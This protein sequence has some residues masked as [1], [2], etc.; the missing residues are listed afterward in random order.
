[1]PKPNF[2]NIAK[3]HEIIRVDHAGEFG[4]QKI[5][6][7]QLAFT[8]DKKFKILIN[9]MLKQEEVHLK[10]FQDQII[11][12]RV[13]PTALMPL[14]NMGGYLLGAF[15]AML[16]V[17][18]AMLLTQSV[19]EVIEEHYQEQLTYLENIKNEEELKNKIEDFLDDE[20]EHKNTAVLHESEQALFAPF[21]SAMIKKICKTAIIISK[22]I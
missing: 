19:E 8:R 17:K 12:H 9:S 2:N 7:G 10:Y 20:I 6:Q 14:W 18:T 15:S 13:R 21:L 1:M 4:A 22:K 5:Y 3:I 11:K 16:G